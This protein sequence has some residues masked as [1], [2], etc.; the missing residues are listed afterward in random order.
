MGAR[1]ARSQS[2][3]AH[4]GRGRRTSHAIG[5]S[6][7]SSCSGSRAWSPLYARPPTGT[8]RV[9]RCNGRSSAFFFLRVGK[10]VDKSRGGWGWG[11]SLQAH[12]R[13]LIRSNFFLPTERRAVQPLQGARKSCPAD[14]SASARQ[15]IAKGSGSN[16]RYHEAML[17]KERTL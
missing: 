1:S 10:K 5:C 16:T 12:G 3:T 9:L 2:R 8:A 11:V 13:Q 6:P 15:L 4:S 7:P 17:I 14:G